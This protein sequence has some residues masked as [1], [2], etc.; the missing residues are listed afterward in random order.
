MIAKR[1]VES[2]A[3]PATESTRRAPDSEFHRTL[4]RNVVQAIQPFVR[5]LQG[6][7]VEVVLRQMRQETGTSDMENETSTA[8]SFQ[9]AAESL[10]ET[11]VWLGRT[12]RALLETVGSLLRTV[13]LLLRAILTGLTQGLRSLWQSIVDAIRDRIINAIVSRIREWVQAIVQRLF[14]DWSTSEELT[15]EVA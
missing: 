8:Q 3:A 13:G 4:R 6:Q 12:V 1:P 9:E 11:F 10:R 2:D 15:Q 5:D 7:I 14:P